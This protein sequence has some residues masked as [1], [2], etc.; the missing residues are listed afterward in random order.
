[1]SVKPI[2][3][4][5]VGSFQNVHSTCS[6]LKQSLIISLSLGPELGEYCAGA[7]LKFERIMR[8]LRQEWVQ[9]L[10]GEAANESLA[11]IRDTSPP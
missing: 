2:M 8:A 3:D 9:W 11:C 4:H 7:G 6:G 10:F 5:A 1:M